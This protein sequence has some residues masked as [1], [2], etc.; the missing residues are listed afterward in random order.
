M[1]EEKTEGFDDMKSYLSIALLSK[2]PYEEKSL[3]KKLDEIDKMKNKILRESTAKMSN[4][5]LKH[6]YIAK[7]YDSKNGEQCRLPLNVAQNSV[8]SLPPLTKADKPQQ[9]HGFDE[10]TSSA[11]F[12]PRI[13]CATSRP[14]YHRSLSDKCLPLS[15]NLAEE[16]G[17]AERENK[18]HSIESQPSNARWLASDRQSKPEYRRSLSEVVAPT[19]FMLADESG[20]AQRRFHAW[21]ENEKQPKSSL[22]RNEATILKPFRPRSIS[23]CV[24][25]KLEDLA[26]EISKENAGTSAK[27]ETAL[28][29]EKGGENPTPD[30]E[31][32]IK[33]RKQF[34]RK[35][36]VA[37][38]TL[39]VWREGICRWQ[40]TVKLVKDLPK[41][42]QAEI[43]RGAC[44]FRM[45]VPGF[46]SSTPAK[47]AEKPARQRKISTTVPPCRQEL[48]PNFTAL[49][50][51]LKTSR[52]Q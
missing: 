21:D 48:T 50:K 34:Q 35:L 41:S 6:L 19:S 38:E 17:V 36:T 52:T 32:I 29:G 43:F 27:D 44:F 2:N 8:C 30:R 7:Y 10:S 40:Q 3:C 51:S 28:D 49:K 24:A 16:K 33:R 9:Q 11:C 13:D 26:Q 4:F 46:N 45:A 31:A 14:K 23:Q 1:D 42:E 22:D 47:P 39:S 20:N 25:P 37:T 12:D 18:A 15:Q 5:A